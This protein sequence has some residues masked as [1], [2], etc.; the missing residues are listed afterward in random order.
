MEHPQKPD[1]DGALPEGFKK[2]I[3]TLLLIIS[4]GCMSLWGVF[5]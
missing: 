5:T 4:I 1:T 2:L 3:G